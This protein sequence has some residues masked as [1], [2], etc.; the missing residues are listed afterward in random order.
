MQGERLR[1]FRREGATRVN[2][3]SW[4]DGPLAWVGR[5]HLH[6]ALSRIIVVRAPADYPPGPGVTLRSA[7]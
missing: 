2:G 1:R 6:T 7:R 5:S 3:L 4:A